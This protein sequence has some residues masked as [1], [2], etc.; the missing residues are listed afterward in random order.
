MINTLKNNELSE[1]EIKDRRIK[2]RCKKGTSNRWL[3]I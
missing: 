3:T 1:K 2:L